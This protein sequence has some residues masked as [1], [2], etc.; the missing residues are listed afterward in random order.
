MRREGADASR[1]LDAVH[2]AGHA[3]VHDHHVR[4]PS[5]QL[6]QRLLAAGSGAHDFDIREGA[7]IGAKAGLHDAVVVDENDADAAHW[8]APSVQG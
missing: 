8:V 7:E 2:A 4:Q 1:G 5:F 6:L 3:E